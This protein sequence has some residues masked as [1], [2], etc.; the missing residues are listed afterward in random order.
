MAAADGILLLCVASMDPND[1]N[2]RDSDLVRGGA[3]A[4]EEDGVE[5]ALSFTA[6]FTVP[7]LI[8]LA[9]FPSRVSKVER[10]M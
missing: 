6:P 2:C 7:K 10:P 1:C 8:G 5:A 4:G 9:A 3:G